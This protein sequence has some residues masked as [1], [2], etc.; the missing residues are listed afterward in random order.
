MLKMQTLRDSQITRQHRHGTG[1]GLARGRDNLTWLAWAT[2]A[3]LIFAGAVLWLLFVVLAA[4][5]AMGG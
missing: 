1:D 3:A 2:F 5:Q 4:T